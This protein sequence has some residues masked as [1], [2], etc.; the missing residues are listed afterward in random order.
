MSA[1]HL[2]SR[3]LSNSTALNKISQIITKGGELKKELSPFGL[4]SNGYIDFRGID[5]SKRRFAKMKIQNVD[6]SY[7]NFQDT[8]IEKSVFSNVLLEKT[9]FSGIT[10]K[11]N[12]FNNVFFINCKLNNSGIGYRGTKYINCTFDNDNFSNAVFIR[13]EYNNS[14]FLNCN[15]KNIDF[16]ASS[17]ESC[18]FTGNLYGAWFRGGYTYPSDEKEFGFAKQNKMENVSFEEAILKGVNFSNECNLSTII[19]PK[20][21]NYKLFNNWKCRLEKLKETI[22][23][24]PELEKKEGEIFINSYLVHAKTQEWFLLNIEEIQ[25]DFGIDVARNIIIALNEF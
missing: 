1:K 7:S 3:W 23:T 2:K 6:L 9:D 17:F 19:L 24:W 5:L 8:W 12:V 21:G 10:D 4:L 22:Q 13:A 16:N 25:Q 11:D 18:K 20:T 15:F 14:T